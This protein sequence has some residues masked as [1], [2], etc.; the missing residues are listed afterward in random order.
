M[1]DSDAA[2]DIHEAIVQ[3]SRRDADDIRPSFVTYYTIG[4]ETPEDMFHMRG[5]VEKYTELCT[6]FF[7]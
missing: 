2:P 7:G 6:S 4:S 1:N 3:W 5:M